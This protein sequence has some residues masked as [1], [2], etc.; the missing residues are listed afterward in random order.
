MTT[1]SVMSAELTSVEIRW[2]AP[3]QYS[4]GWYATFTI[5]DLDTLRTYLGTGTYNTCF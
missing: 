3:P 4:G 2:K 5:T 1:T